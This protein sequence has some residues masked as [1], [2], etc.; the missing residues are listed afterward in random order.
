MS[1]NSGSAGDTRGRKVGRLFDGK[2]YRKSNRP[3][4]PKA[5]GIWKYFKQRMRRGSGKVPINLLTI[6]TPHERDRALLE[7]K[8]D[9]IITHAN[10]VVFALRIKALKVGNLLESLG[11]FDLF[12]H[13]LDS[14][15]ESG[16]GDDGQIRVEGFA[17]KRFHAARSRRWK[18][19]LRL[20]IGDFSPS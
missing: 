13:F 10:A 9:A 16:V 7:N 4:L 20:M 15:Q 14:S 19:F 3:A 12:N 2:C 1:R 5:I 18:I 17:K 11:G 6:E 8:T